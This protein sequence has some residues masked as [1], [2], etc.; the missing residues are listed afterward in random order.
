MGRDPVARFELGDT[1]P[2][3]LD[4]AGGVDAHHVRETLHHPE[5]PAPHVG[6]AMVHARRASADDDV[7]E[8]RLGLRGILEAKLLDTPVVVQ[9]Y[10]FHGERVSAPG[11]TPLSLASPIAASLGTVPAIDAPGRDVPDARESCPRRRAF[12]VPRRNRRYPAN[13]SA[14]RRPSLAVAAAKSGT[15]AT[16]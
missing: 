5:Q 11:R 14:Q 2:D 12:Q 13:I 1:G 3:R 8:A 6:V 16:P 15:N 7:V 4:L 9:N 10:R